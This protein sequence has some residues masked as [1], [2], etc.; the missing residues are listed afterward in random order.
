MVPDTVQ[1]NI[2]YDS[3][4]E[5]PEINYELRNTVQKL[6]SPEAKL[7]SWTNE[8]MVRRIQDQPTPIAIRDLKT[9]IRKDRE[10]EITEETIKELNELE[11]NQTLWYIQNL[12]TKPRQV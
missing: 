5:L 10:E 6:R 4:L 9:F 7:K 8:W 11:E 3:G 1:Y 12:R 2:H